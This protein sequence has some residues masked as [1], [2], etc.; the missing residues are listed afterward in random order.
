MERNPSVVL[1]KP[2]AT[3]INRITAFNKE[4]VTLF[5]NNLEKVQAKYKIQAHRIF[6]TDETG[7]S[8]VQTPG[9]ILGQKGLK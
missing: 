2:E 6:N 4:E 7:V 8:T 5:F 1:R 9:K 3:S